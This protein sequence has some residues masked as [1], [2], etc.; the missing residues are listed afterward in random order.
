MELVPFTMNDGIWVYSAPGSTES[1]N[2]YCDERL[3]RCGKRAME[4]QYVRLHDDFFLGG[5]EGGD[6]ET[7]LPALLVR[8]GGF[9]RRS[10]VPRP[11][12]LFVV[13]KND[14]S[15]LVFIYFPVRNGFEMLLPRTGSEI[16]VR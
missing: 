3:S 12:R 14:T 8:N 2:K 1:T 9:L 5:A 13:K 4:L 6:V 16:F 7:Y 15:V 10:A 11:L